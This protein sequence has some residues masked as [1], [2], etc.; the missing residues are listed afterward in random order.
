[1]E[2]QYLIQYIVKGYNW[3]EQEMVVPKE[4]AIRMLSDESLLILRM[5][6]Q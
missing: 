6:I 4:R 2:T 5:E 3:S 1:M